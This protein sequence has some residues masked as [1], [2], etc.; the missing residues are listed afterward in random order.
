MFQAALIPDFNT[1]VAETH[2]FTAMHNCVQRQPQL[3]PG[4]N[5]NKYIRTLDNKPSGI[6]E[7]NRTA[8]AARAKLELA[9]TAQMVN[10][11]HNV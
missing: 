5:T 2:I 11:E 3:S 4:T 7:F 10:K 1:T 8:L 6:E 9:R